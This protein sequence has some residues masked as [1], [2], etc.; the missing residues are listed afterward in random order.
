MDRPVG[1]DPLERSDGKDPFDFRTYYAENGLTITTM[2]DF[3]T[4][5]AAFFETYIRTNTSTDDF[6]MTKFIKLITRAEVLF[7]RARAVIPELQVPQELSSHDNANVR[8]VLLATRE[9]RGSSTKRWSNQPEGLAWLK[10]VS[11]GGVLADKQEKEKQ[12]LNASGQTSPST[13]LVCGALP[14]NSTDPLCA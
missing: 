8:Q 12:A 2:I 6:Y 11:E 13:F 7:K 10:L 14:M 4:F 1:K 3:R 9:L 5:C